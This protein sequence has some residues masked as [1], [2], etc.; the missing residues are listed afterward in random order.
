MIY[1][2]FRKPRWLI[3]GQ[4]KATDHPRHFI[5]AGG[6]GHGVL[7][8]PRRPI[9]LKIAK[10]AFPGIPHI[11]FEGRPQ[12]IS[13]LMRPRRALLLAIII[14]RHAAIAPVAAMFEILAHCMKKAATST[15]TCVVFRSQCMDCRKSAPWAFGKVVM[16]HMVCQISSEERGDP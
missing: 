16:L 3:I 12:C 7:T 13:G 6:G 14:L 10:M 11:P 4:L 5:Q 8:G 1:R 9:L 15:E 2:N